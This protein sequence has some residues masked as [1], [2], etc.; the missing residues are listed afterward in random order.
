MTQAGPNGAPK[1]SPWRVVAHDDAPAPLDPIDWSDLKARVVAGLDVAAEF[2]ALGVEFTR[3]L[4]TARGLRECR[5]FGRKDER[6]SAFVNVQTGVYHDSGGEGETL[7]LFDF[8]A[9]HGRFG[10]WTEVLRHYAERAGVPFHPGRTRSGGRVEEAHYDYRDESGSVRYR[11]FR[12]RLPNGKK[13][14]T[15]HPSDGKGGWRHGPGCMDGVEPL[16]Y[17]LPELLAADPEETVFVVEGE[18][19]ADRL[20]ALGLVATTNHQGAQSTDLTWPKFL[21]YFRGRDVVAIPDND[22]GGRRHVEKVCALLAPVARSVRRLDLPGLAARG[23]VS[24]WLDTGHDLDELGHLAYAAPAWTPAPE[25]APRPV[26][27]ATAADLI[28]AGAGITWLWRGWIARGVLTLLAAESDTG[29]TRFCLDLARRVNLG[30]PWPDGQPADAT[31]G[32]RTLWVAADSQHSELADATVAHRMDPWALVLNTTPDDLYG[33]TELATDEQFA[34]LEAN[35]DEVRPAFV[36][37]DTITNTSELK[38][39]DASDAKKQYK[40]LQQI[41]KRTGVPILVVTHLN[42]RGKTLGRRAD[43]KVRV[44]IRMEQPDKDD[45]RRR[46]EVHKSR[47]SLK[48][49]PLGVKMSDG[50]NEYDT[51]PPDHPE[52]DVFGHVARKQAGFAS[53][54]LDAACDWLRATLGPGRRRVSDV[55][56]EAE[57]AEIATN[58]LYRAKEKLG[59][60]EDSPDGRKWWRMPAENGDF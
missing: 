18:K 48:P 28:A 53:P 11:V 34:Q 39:T 27:L 47:L 29:K 35:I 1:A 55:R 41:A 51:S 32:A 26:R 36:I 24:D 38:A 52:P 60:V 3:S 46:V 19:D 44:T 22:E 54:R 45:E 42:D 10:S 5:A 2:A 23:D 4:P 6:P 49:P 9:R 7:H 25:A 12:Y 21:G 15:Q 37:I 20:A 16:P 58:T 50:G 56:R 13:T 33:G 31:P 30:L 57:A 43:E 8:A 59:V 17:R 40:P 14:F